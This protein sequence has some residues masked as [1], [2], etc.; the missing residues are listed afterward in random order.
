MERIKQGEI[1]E[2]EHIATVEN[3]TT[4]AIILSDGFKKEITIPYEHYKQQRLG[5]YK[6]LMNGEEFVQ[7]NKDYFELVKTLH[8]LMDDLPEN[9]KT[10]IWDMVYKRFEP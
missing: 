10:K 9:T 5:K 4:I 2:I 7:I 8:N 6:R 3:K 1:I